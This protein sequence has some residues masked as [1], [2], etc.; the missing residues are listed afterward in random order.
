MG[1]MLEGGGNPWRGMVYGM[2]NRYP[3]SDNADP[4]NL[5]KEWD[6]FG[7]KGTNMIGYWS[8][9]CPVKTSEPK[10]LATV[11]QK[12]GA[13]M[14][15]IASW[16]PADTN[17]RLLI[18]WKKLGIDPDKAILSVPYIKNFQ[19]EKTIG[20]NEVLPVEKSKGLIIIIKEK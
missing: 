3:W 18:D 9:N 5:W 19:Q 12:P 15:S 7:M 11:Y 6:A 13:A 4:R 2:T 1:E 16:A 20:L 14:I 17:V 10:V 8:V